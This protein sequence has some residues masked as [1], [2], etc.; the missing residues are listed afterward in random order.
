MRTPSTSSE[1]SAAPATP[2]NFIA[3]KSL[4]TPSEATL[5]AAQPPWAVCFHKPSRARLV[6]NPQP[7]DGL[8]HLGSHAPH[9]T[10]SLQVPGIADDPDKAGGVRTVGYDALASFEGV[11]DTPVAFT[12]ETAD[13]EALEPCSLPEATN[14]E[15][16]IS[17]L[18]MQE[19]S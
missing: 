9:L 16:H 11:K 17:H 5:A 2:L 10:S 7:G 6:R 18:L 1:Q 14:I 4:A 8:A 19:S 15:R 12:V 13:A 3:P